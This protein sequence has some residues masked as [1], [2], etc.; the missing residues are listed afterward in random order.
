V[1]GREIA[2]VGALTGANVALAS[3]VCPIVCHTPLADDPGVSGTRDTRPDREAPSGAPAEA[4]ADS[5]KRLASRKKKSW[6]GAR[7]GAGRP[8]GSGQGSSPR[9]RIHR[10]AVMLSKPE[11]ERL[12]KLAAVA[13][14]PLATLA[15]ELLIRAM[16]NGSRRSPFI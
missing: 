10:V 5:E 16:R 3:W 9:A 11:L 4:L 12:L 14:K 13:D 6:G 15:Y 7:P 2:R 1:P 8:K